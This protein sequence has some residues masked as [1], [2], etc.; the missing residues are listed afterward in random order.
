MIQVLTLAYLILLSISTQY[1][2]SHPTPRGLLKMVRTRYSVGRDMQNRKG[3]RW[4]NERERDERVCV[5][6]GLVAQPIRV[7]HF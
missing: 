7:L 2:L 4:G 5:C 3:E 6:V 1:L